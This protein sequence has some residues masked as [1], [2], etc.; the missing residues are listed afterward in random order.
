MR[1]ERSISPI[2]RHQRIYSGS[3]RAEA[4]SIVRDNTLDPINLAVDASGNLLVLSSDGRNG[5]VYSFK[6]GSPDTQ[7]EV[8]AATPAVD[9]V[10]A[11]TVL[12]GQLVE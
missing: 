12:A 6:P 1:P 3:E 2:V 7:V 9:H 11:A 10:S 4:L 5:S 8:V